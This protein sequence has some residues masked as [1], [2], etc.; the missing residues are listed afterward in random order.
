[1][2]LNY[3]KFGKGY[4]ISVHTLLGIWLLI[5]SGIKVYQWRDPSWFIRTVFSHRYISCRKA[6]ACTT[7]YSILQ[8]RYVTIIQTLQWRHN[9]CD[10]VSNH[11]HHHFLLH[12]LFR[13]RSKKTS[14]LRVTGLCEGNSPVTGQFP[15]QMASNAENVS[16]WWRHHESHLD[17]SV[18]K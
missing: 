2:E 3:L 4:V 16:I 14:K 10:S 9:G 6:G 18:T 13:C 12:R 1:M 15:A 7:N 17:F 11:Q 5:P 8:A